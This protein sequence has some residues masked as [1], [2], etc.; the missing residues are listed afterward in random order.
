MTFGFG[1]ESIAKCCSGLWQFLTARVNGRTAVELERERN[2]GTAEVIKVLPPGAELLENEPNGR[3]RAAPDAPPPGSAPSGERRTAHPVE[4]RAQRVSIDDHGQDFD[5]FFRQHNR[6]LRGFLAK[7]VGAPPNIVDEAGP[8]AFLAVRR[9]WARLR[10][11]AP[12]Q[13]LFKVGRDERQ[14]SS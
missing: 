12:K 10:D 8:I 13:Y 6:R 4:G 7:T 9:H 2:R 14:S 3:L 1:L 11:E 5:G